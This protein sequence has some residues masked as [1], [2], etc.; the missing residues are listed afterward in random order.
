MESVLVGKFEDTLVLFTKDG[1]NCNSSYYDLISI[2]HIW[3]G[4][5]RMNTMIQKTISQHLA[6]G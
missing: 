1:N 2:H 3:K 6:E 4:S 5:R